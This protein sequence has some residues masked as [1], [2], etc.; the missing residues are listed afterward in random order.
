MPI[1]S[2]E[3]LVA[4]TGAHY[5][6][7]TGTVSGGGM[8]YYDAYTLSGRALGG[9]YTQDDDPSAGSYG[10]ANYLRGLLYAHMHAIV[11]AVKAAH[12]GAKFEWLLPMDVNA[13]SVYW[14][15]GYPYPQGGRMNHYVNI[16]SQYQVPNGDIDRVKIE[17]LSFGNVYYNLDL[18]KAMMVY[19]S[20]VL[21]YAK[22]DT[23]Y[24]VPWFTG[25]CAWEKHYLAA[26]N[27]GI[28]LI[29]FWAFD[30]LVL[31]SWRVP[32]PANGRGG[33]ARVF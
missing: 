6:A 32:L 13:P 10:D 15:R 22:A 1:L 20:A 23:A 27:S 19:A 8:A 31:L 21:T 16:P 29:G 28:P 5:V 33:G 9:W 4:I 18:A 7:A 3:T 2:G 30:H 11:A 17:C 26:T 25:G 24:L 14:N 12:A